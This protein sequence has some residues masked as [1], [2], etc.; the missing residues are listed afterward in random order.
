MD[1]T[2][3]LFFQQNINQI[4]KGLPE[5]D[6]LTRNIIWFYMNEMVRDGKLKLL[7][8]RDVILSNIPDEPEDGIY[9]FE[10]QFLNEST[11]SYIPSSIRKD[12]RMVIF[13]FI[14]EQLKGFNTLKKEGPK[15]KPVYLSRVPRQNY[16]SQIFKIF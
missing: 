10:L 15:R 12:A 7:P 6:A 8:Y 11:G 1:D 5:N 9:S 4:N 13:D 2:S 14:I 16:P 3:L